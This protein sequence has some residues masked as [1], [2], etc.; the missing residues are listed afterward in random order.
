MA[1][2]R[3]YHLLPM[4]INEPPGDANDALEVWRTVLMG[5]REVVTP[6]NELAWR[7]NLLQICHN[8]S[9]RATTG[10]QKLAAVEACMATAEKP[11]WFNWM[12]QNILLLWWEQ[13]EVAEAVATSLRAGEE[14]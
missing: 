13:E 7:D 4:E 3:L 12:S 14:F 11:Q 6:S 10:I 1:A 2:L 8:V 5:Q 9:E